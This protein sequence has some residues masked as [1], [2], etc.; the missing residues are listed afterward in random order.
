MLKYEYVPLKLDGYKLVIANTNKRR[1]LVDSAYND[2]RRE[3]EEAVADL[4][5]KFDIEFLCELTPE[6]FDANSGLI[7]DPVVRKRA[8]HAIHENARALEAVKALRA[9]DLA[10]FG[11]LMNYSH[12]SLRDLYEVTGPELDALAEE[13]WQVQGVL[14]SRMTGAGFG[15]CTVSIVEE[16]AVDDFI[17]AVGERYHTHTGLTA[18]F[19]IADVGDGTN[20]LL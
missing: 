15:G 9:G 2:R 11:K 6:Q 14:G 8:E 19:Y 3:C 16:N 18:D 4:R 5:A 1:G 7:H 17:R 12:I 20:R 10:T 13:A